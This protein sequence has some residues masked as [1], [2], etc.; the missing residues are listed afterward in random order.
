MIYSILMDIDSRIAEIENTMADSAF[1]SDS[2]R[3]QSIIAEYQTLIQRRDSGDDSQNAGPFDAYTATISIS[4]GAGGDD[5]EDFVRMLSEM[6]QAYA[7]NHG[8]PVYIVDSSPNEMNGYRSVQL[9]VD[10]PYA[11]GALQYE[12]GVHRLIRMSPFNAKGKRQTS[13]ALV[14]VVPYI[15][16]D[17]S[18]IILN[19]SEID[20]QF[21]KS[22]GKGGQNV[23]K[24]ETAVR[25]THTPSGIVSYADGQRTQE[26]NRETAMTMLR[27][28]LALVKLDEYR[29]Q[30]DGMRIGGTVENEWGS[31]IRTY[32]LHPYTL[33]KDHR[34]GVE[35]S[36]V[37]KVLSRGEIEQF[38]E[39]LYNTG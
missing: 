36:S 5:S 3:A 20:I 24:R 22:G 37:D 8:F 6:Y 7:K 2:T 11:F 21:T 18:E 14:E 15:E 39:G 13:F 34:T 12:S 17:T 9:K 38:T 26:S 27:G 30:M 32:T 16:Q 19:P 23:N 1:W 35:T 4:A 33:V 25:I 31:Q 28:K 29:K 10:A